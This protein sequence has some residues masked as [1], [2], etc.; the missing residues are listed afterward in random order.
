ME[1]SAGVRA[2][3][4]RKS[5]LNK[6]VIILLAA[7]LVCGGIV[8]ALYS[9]ATQKEERRQAII[10][11]PTFPQGVTIGGVDVSG[12]GV[13]EAREALRPRLNEIFLEMLALRHRMA[14]NA[15]VADFR[16]YSWRMLHRHEYTPEDCLR[17][18]DA[19]AQVVVP[20]LRQ[21][22]QRRQQVMGLDA[23]R[24]YDLRPDVRGR[25]PLKPFR[26][27]TELE[28]GLV[29]M[30]SAVDPAVGEGFEL[31]RDG[32]LDIESR[33]GKVPGLGYQSYFAA[34]RMPFIYMN[35]VGTDD[36]MLIMRHEMGHALHTLQ[37]QERWP[38]LV[39][40]S[41]RPEMNELASQALEFL[42]LPY[43]AASEGGFYSAEDAQRS[44]AS[45]L[46]RALE[47]LVQACRIDA[48]QH[49]IY[50]HPGLQ[51]G[52]GPSAEDIDAAWLDI[53]TRFDVGV[54]YTGFERAQS[55]G[56]QYFHV[57]QIPFYY[58]EYAIAY[59]GALQ[60]WERA[61]GDQAAALKDYLEAL[62]LGATR[63]LNE[64]YGAAGI[65]FDFDRGMIER[66]TD[67]VV[68]ELGDE[69]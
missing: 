42:T 12:I 45:L 17:M 58:I 6:V 11:A 36:D 56:W 65:S 8:Y 31:L 15:G 68:L 7:L 4:P 44:R 10:N 63:P 13:D 23:L 41:E 53:G 16:E 24:P 52:T 55:R 50:T 38:L 59:L 1:N 60:V 32:W 67:L 5:K 51:D 28:E 27:V 37:T 49:F 34:T 9:N 20:R 33:P 14:R 62:S 40:M 47:L 43:L 61:K 35:A 21:V 2:G 25:E 46:V 39:H 69:A 30:F 66:L 57:F 29:R 3:T 22:H 19:V 26:T 18:H 54:D 64:L 48:I